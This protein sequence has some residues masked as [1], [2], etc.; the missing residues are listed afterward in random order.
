MQ[1]FY[2][3]PMKEKKTLIEIYPDLSD[4]VMNWLDKA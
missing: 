3:T 1:L 2:S 4:W